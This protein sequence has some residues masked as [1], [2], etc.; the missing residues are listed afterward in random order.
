MKKVITLIVRQEHT[1]QQ[2]KNEYD[3]A[4]NEAKKPYR[5]KCA[6]CGITDVDHKDMLFRYCSKCNGE[7]AYCEKHIKNHEHIK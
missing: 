6:V 2:V 3:K 1:E 7:Y 5:H 4:F